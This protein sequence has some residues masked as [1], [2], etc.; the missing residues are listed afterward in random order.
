LVSAGSAESLRLK[1]A[2]SPA[3]APFLPLLAFG[4]GGRLV[5][6]LKGLAMS[7][8]RRSFA[9]LMNYTWVALA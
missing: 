1:S 8:R 7:P 3:R 4:G 9:W 2:L 5:S 6:A